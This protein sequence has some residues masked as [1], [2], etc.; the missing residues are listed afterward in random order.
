MTTESDLFSKKTVKDLSLFWEK[1][2]R[3]KDVVVCDNCL[4]LVGLPTGY[5]K[6]MELPIL[7]FN[8][9]QR[10][11]SKDLYPLLKVITFEEY[12][13]KLEG[14]EIQYVLLHRSN[15]SFVMPQMKVVKIINGWKIYS[16]KEKNVPNE[17]K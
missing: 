5:L 13:L 10:N 7:N 1:T 16:N 6:G 9:W 14:G 3:D 11:I 12:K 17:L 4:S 8:I 15:P 2:L